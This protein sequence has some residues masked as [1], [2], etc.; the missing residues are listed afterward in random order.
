MEDKTKKEQFIYQLQVKKDLQISIHSALVKQGIVDI[1]IQDL[2][3]EEPKDSSHGDYSSNIALKLTKILKKNP[4]EIANSLADELKKDP[5]LAKIEVASPGFINFFVSESTLSQSLASITSEKFK[6]DLAKKLAGKKVMVEFTD[7][8]PFKE[9]HIGHMYSNSV[10]E[11]IARLYEVL[12]ADVRK[13]CY[14]GDVGMHVAKSVWG[15]VKSFEELGIKTPTEYIAKQNFSEKDSIVELTNFLG[16]CYA[17][18]ASAYE[19]TE[20]FKEEIKQINKKIYDKTDEYINLLYDWGREKSLEYFEYAYKKLGMIPRKA[21]TAFDFY[22]FESKVADKGKEV[23]L[24]NKRLFKESDGAIIFPGEEYGLHSRVFINSMGLPTY[25]AKELGLAPAKFEK[26][27]YDKSI[28][29]TGNEIKE[30]FKVLL[31]VLSLISPELEEKTTHLTHGMVRLP[32]G[33]MSSRKG[34]VKTALWLLEEVKNKAAQANS[35][36]EGKPEV[37]SDEA[38]AI[39]AIKYSFL[40]ITLGNDIEFD[41][42]NALSF[43]G[44]SGPYLLYTYVR[45]RSVLSKESNK[46]SDIKFSDEAELELA[47]EL[48][49]FEDMVV[50]AALGYSPNILCGYLHEVSQKYNAFYNKLSI[51]NAESEEIK[52]A[53]LA[54]TEATS[55]VLKN[56]L[57]LLGIETVERM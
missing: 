57:N 7:P 23:V 44:D 14:Q 40:K 47:K 28:I 41:I 48:I 6:S 29:I 11:S 5:L 20:T 37:D 31:K 51:L 39:A 46:S 22:F 49:K 9:F 16:K 12:G 4:I 45:A 24:T 30:Y 38:I 33:K 10:G 18:G 34:N 53:R 35:E 26:F 32:E 25:E 56:G 15:I 8:N 54:L 43:Q 19:E 27:P 36:K 52:Q 2:Q 17:K 1:G 50:S 55:I 21:G 42:D 3:I 13:A